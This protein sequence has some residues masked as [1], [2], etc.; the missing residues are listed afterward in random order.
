MGP[1][2]ACAC[3]IGQI[4]TR[5]GRGMILQLD[6]KFGQEILATCDIVRRKIANLLCVMH[7]FSLS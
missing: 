4:G 6:Y 3:A 7:V 1:H 5:P 2:C